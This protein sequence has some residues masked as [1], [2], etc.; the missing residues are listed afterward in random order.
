MGKAAMAHEASE[1]SRAP[2]RWGSGDG[3]SCER[4]SVATREVPHGGEAEPSQQAAREGQAWLCGMAERSVVPKKPGN[5]GGGKGP[6][7]WRPAERRKV[8]VIG[9]SL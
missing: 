1:K 2:V 5:A 3:M 7:F 8:V 6:W 4:R 9:E